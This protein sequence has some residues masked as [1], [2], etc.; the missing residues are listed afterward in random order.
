MLFISKVPKGSK[1]LTEMSAAAKLEEFKRWALKAR[2][3]RI[4]LF[5]HQQKSG[6]ITQF[7]GILLSCVDA[8]SLAL[9][10]FQLGFGL[11]VVEK[12]FSIGR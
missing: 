12:Y 5:K 2:L 1:D 7:L 4:E 10:K 3:E 11:S 8:K 9:N 6:V